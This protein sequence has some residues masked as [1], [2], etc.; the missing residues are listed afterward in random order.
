[1]WPVVLIA[2][3][4]IFF[5][6]VFCRRVQVSFEWLPPL[7]ARLSRSRG[8]SQAADGA[9]MERLRAS[10]SRATAQYAS[11]DRSSRFEPDATGTPATPTVIDQMHSA[12]AVEISQAPTDAPAAPV[13]DDPTTTEFTERLLEVKKRM[14][15]GRERPH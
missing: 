14:R 6:D 12:T 8:K 10:K 2:T 13:N 15:D 11:A 5:A 3:S 9:Q 4:L 1:M 7:L